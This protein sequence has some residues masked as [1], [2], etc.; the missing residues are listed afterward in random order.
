[1]L[2]IGKV[3]FAPRFFLAISIIGFILD[4][5]SF[6]LAVIRTYNLA[7]I[8]TKRFMHVLDTCTPSS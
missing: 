2:C 4:T 8:P 3:C 5:S 1:M 7:R 6:A